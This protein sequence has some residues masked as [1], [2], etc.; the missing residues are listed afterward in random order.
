MQAVI[1]LTILVLSC[2]L[3]GQFIALAF[4]L[5]CAVPDC[6]SNYKH[7][8]FDAQTKYTGLPA[9]LGANEKQIYLFKYRG[10]VL[11]YKK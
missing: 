4:N 2:L 7:P 1:K 6:G 10:Q 8:G 3:G 9:I 5:Y 11:R